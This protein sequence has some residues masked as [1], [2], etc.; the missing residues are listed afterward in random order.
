V[1]QE[2]KEEVVEGNVRREEEYER[3]REVLTKR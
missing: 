1:V 3:M 2:E